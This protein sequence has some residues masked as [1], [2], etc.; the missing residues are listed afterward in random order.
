V[1]TDG[2]AWTRV[3]DEQEQ[4]GGPSLQQINALI[5]WRGTLAA[6]GSDGSGGEDDAA[7][8]LATPSES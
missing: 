4:F 5:V 2:Y 1:S 3:P 6:V 8:W 7:V